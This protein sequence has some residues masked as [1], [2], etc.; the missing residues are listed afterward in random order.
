MNN[1]LTELAGETMALIR[2]YAAKGDDVQAISRL[3]ETATKIK[4]LQENLV[5]VEQEAN[6][7]ENYLN[8]FSKISKDEPSVNYTT[9][10]INFSE[11]D[12]A[13]RSQGKK[14]HIE[15][16]W[17]RLQK[18]GGQEVICEHQASETMT[19]FIQ[20]LYMVYG[21]SIFDKL[22]TF[23]ISRG[24]IVSKDP[25]RDFV[26]RSKGTPY[27]H[28]EIRGTGFSVLTHSQTSQ[29]VGDLKEVCRYLNFPTGAVTISE[30]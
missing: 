26:N 29:K 11:F 22:S 25:N 2:Q 8:G 19:K 13:R 1:K 28:Q 3:S 14:L 23:R 5:A 17:Q 18:P 24:P 4:S 12:Y 7:I 10:P 6:K 21:T 15:I 27:S 20:R 16:D 30:V 9:P